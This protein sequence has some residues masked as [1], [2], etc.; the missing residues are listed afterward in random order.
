MTPRVSD[1]VDIINTVAPFRYAESWDNVGLQLGDPAMPVSRLMVA[2]DPSAS[3]IEE[4]IAQ[5]CQLLL[6]HH[7]LIFK[8]LH[9]I[10]LSSPSG[11]LIASALRN[12]LAI[13]TLHTNYDSA[14]GGLNDL[15][16]ARLGIADAKPLESSPADE[17]VKLA[18]FVPLGHEEQILQAVF[19]FSGVMGNYRECSFRVEGVGTFSP[20]EGAQP[21]IGSV[22]RRE[23]VAE[24]RIEVLLRRTAVAEATAALCAAHPYE[25]PA[26]DLV[27]LL[28]RSGEAGLGRIGDLDAPV[29]LDCFAA[30]IKEQC[31]VGGLRTVGDG[32]KILKRVALCSGSGASLLGMALRQG[33]DVLVTGDIKYHDA[34]DAEEQGI[35]LI[36]MGHFASERIMVAGLMDTLQRLLPERGF[37]DTQVIAAAERDVFSYH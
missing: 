30:R 31:A 33:A 2:L 4:A 36:D 18:V 34:R 24:A 35:A 8:P 37:P 11:L 5:S 1:I 21:F 22:G 3:V 32:G 16:A 14:P 17:L 10:D 26:F 6:T 20:T 25:E 9:R 23:S 7:P 15:L 19:P 28:N 12:S 27:P 29:T 13:V